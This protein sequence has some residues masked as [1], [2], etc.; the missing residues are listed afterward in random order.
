MREP[1]GLEN[2]WLF[3]ALATKTRLAYLAFSFL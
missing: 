3:A 1:V 2:R